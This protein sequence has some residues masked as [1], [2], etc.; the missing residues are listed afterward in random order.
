MKKNIFI[1]F[2]V[3]VI[4][5]GC[6]YG[7]FLYSAPK[8]PPLTLEIEKNTV[9]EHVI[10]TA[11]LPHATVYSPLLITGEARGSWFFEASFPVYL[12]DSHG[13]ALGQ[14]VAQAQG[15]WMTTAF[16]P[17]T[18]TLVF[19]ADPQILGDEGMLV[20]QKDNPSGLH[21]NDDELRISVII[22]AKN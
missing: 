20:L 17:F 4:F 6:F 9:L 19:T 21:E 18:A 22:G 13:N 16:V 7:V 2:V 12:L 14:G 3:F 10:V 1:A 8:A 15:D 5:G 11:P